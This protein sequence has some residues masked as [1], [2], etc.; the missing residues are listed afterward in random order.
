MPS[1][2]KD[3]PRPTEVME[4]WRLTN[5]PPKQWRS[6]AMTFWQR[7]NQHIRGQDFPTTKPQNA[8]DEVF[9]V[10]FEV[11]HKHACVYVKKNCVVSWLRPNMK[12]HI[13]WQISNFPNANSVKVAQTW[14]IGSADGQNIHMAEAH[15]ERWPHAT[16]NWSQAPVHLS[17]G[18][19]VLDVAFVWMTMRPRPG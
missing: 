14:H 6:L 4:F 8:I 17:V 19:W 12:Y 18:Y 10:M 7:K 3:C 9:F 15:M 11:L 13:P 16:H 2:S 5:K 1:S